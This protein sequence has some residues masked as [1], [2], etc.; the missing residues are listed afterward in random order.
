M[1]NFL[2]KLNLTFHYGGTVKITEQK[3]EKRVRENAF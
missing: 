1:G 3:H 2:K